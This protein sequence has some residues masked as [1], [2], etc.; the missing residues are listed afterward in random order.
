VATHTVI[1]MPDKQSAIQ[2][3]LD[4]LYAKRKAPE[5]GVAVDQ[6][7]KDL[8][9]Q[10]AIREEIDRLERERAELVRHE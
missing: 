4:T 7:L 6:T 5:P 10:S 1:R 2:E 3:R 8:E 9:E